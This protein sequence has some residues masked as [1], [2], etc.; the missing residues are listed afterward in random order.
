MA[1]AQIT[2]VAVDPTPDDMMAQC[3]AIESERRRWLKG[4]TA[5][6]ATRSHD[7]DPSSAVQTAADMAMVAA[8]D[9]V[10]RLMRGD[11]PIDIL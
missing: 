6:V 11:D 7:S 1:E 3:V 4:I 9:R 5:F 2:E 8:Y 10:A